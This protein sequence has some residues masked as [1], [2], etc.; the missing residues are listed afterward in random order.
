M[1][2][3]DRDIVQDLIDGFFKTAGQSGWNGEVTEEVAEV[4]YLMLCSAGKCS[5]A[6]AWIPRPPA[7]RPTIRWLADQLGRIARQKISNS[8]SV[9]CAQRAVVNWRRPLALAEKGFRTEAAVP[10]E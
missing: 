6:L 8:I 7:G 9:I 4:F 2:A 3:S 1:S 10:C 5:E